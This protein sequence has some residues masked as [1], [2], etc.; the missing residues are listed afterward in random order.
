MYM[1]INIYKNPDRTLH[2]HLFHSVMF[3]IKHIFL[4]IIHFI[5]FV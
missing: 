5:K 4:E 1:E 2:V 3:D